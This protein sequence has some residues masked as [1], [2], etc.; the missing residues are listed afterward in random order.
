MATINEPGGASP[1][2]DGRELLRR[3]AAMLSGTLG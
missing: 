2:E 1:S 3:T